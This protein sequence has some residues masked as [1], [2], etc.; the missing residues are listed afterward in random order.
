M[1]HFGSFAM[2]EFDHGSNVQKLETTATYDPSSESFVIHTPHKRAMK[3]WIGGLAET[4]TR[5]VVFA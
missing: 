4:S 1:D 5:L 2:T 3:F